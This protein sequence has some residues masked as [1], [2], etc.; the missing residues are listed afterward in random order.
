MSARVGTIIAGCCVACSAF[1]LGCDGEDGEN[2]IVVTQDSAGVNVVTNRGAGL[3]ATRAIRP[4]TVADSPLVRIGVA[5]GD[6][7]YELRL[8]LSAVR[9]TDGRLIVGNA[10]T[11]ELRVYDSEGHHLRSVGRDGEGPG[12][13]RNIRGVWRYR[14]DSLVVY[15]P[16]LRRVSVFDVDPSFTR[17]FPLASPG[18]GLAPSL[19]GVFPDG[20]FLVRGSAPVTPALG[21]GVHR[22]PGPVLRYGTAGSVGDTIAFAMGEEWVGIDATRG[23][24]LMRRPFGRD[25]YT[26]VVGRNVA[27]VDGERF[28]IRIHTPQGDLLRRIRRSGDN[29]RITP[30]ERSSFVQSQLATAR[31]SEA[32]RRVREWMEEVPMHAFYPVVTGMLVDTEV[33]LWLGEPRAAEEV[34]RRYTVIDEEGQLLGQVTLPAGLRPLEVGSDYV[35]G[36][37]VDDLGVEYIQMHRLEKAR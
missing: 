37:V 8:A 16:S 6:P 33:N 24:V 17:S 5:Q 18:D 12:E 32:A 26:A 1:L 25:S 20:S 11:S 30:E 4:W 22:R 14:T 35:L 36:R 9:V 23:I 3:W 10:G 31:S 13:F 21:V 29:R 28:E 27:M 34:A 7:S 2:G 15:D 19:S